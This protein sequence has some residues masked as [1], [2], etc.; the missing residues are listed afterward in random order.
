MRRVLLAK[1]SWLD[2]MPVLIAQAE[3]RTA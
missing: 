3:N 2:K 1:S